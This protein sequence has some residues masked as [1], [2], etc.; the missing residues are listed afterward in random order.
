MSG[1]KA[2][3]VRDP[4]SPHPAPLVRDRRFEDRSQMD[5][6]HRGARSNLLLP[7]LE[8]VI[9]FLGVAKGGYNLA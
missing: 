2:T 5:A 4:D 3:F 7:N 1:I 6:E 8:D 9:L